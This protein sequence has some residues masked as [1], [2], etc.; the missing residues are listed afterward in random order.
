M[1]ARTVLALTCLGLVAVPLAAIAP[2]GGVGQ[3]DD[4]PS[5]ETLYDGTCGLCHGP[6]GI[7][8][9][10]PRIAPMGRELFEVLEIVRNGNG[11]M[12]AISEDELSDDE[13]ARVVA[14]LRSVGD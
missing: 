12:P 13:V 4:A 3:Q 6:E 5:G 7:G 11:Q 10:G 14:Y 1:W 2:A 8:D 9:A